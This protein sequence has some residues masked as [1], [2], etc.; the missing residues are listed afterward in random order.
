[1]RDQITTA[2]NENESSSVL[3]KTCDK[4]K[5]TLKATS[6]WQQIK[7][8]GVSAIKSGQP[9]SQL[10]EMLDYLE[11][12]GFF[13]VK[14]GEIE[15]FVPT[16]GLH[17]PKWVAQALAGDI[18]T[19]PEFEAA[20]KFVSEVFDIGPNT[21]WCQSPP[22]VSEVKIEAQPKDLPEILMDVL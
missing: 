6:S 11:D 20:R 16:I 17:G 5:L 8:S 1:V 3:D 4:I 10:T 15:R 13:V 12:H 7:L 18:S 9:S 21:G 19:D 14:C 22:S 2:L